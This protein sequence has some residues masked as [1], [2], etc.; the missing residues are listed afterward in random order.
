MSTK[1]RVL[2]CLAGLIAVLAGPACWAGA[3]DTVAGPAA[4]AVPWC[5]TAQLHGLI[6]GQNAGAGSI[7]TTLVLRNAGRTTCMLMGYP[8]VSLVDSRHRQLGRPARWDAGPIVRIV[9]RPGDA[10][11]TMIRS[12]NPGTGTN[13]CL[14]PSAALRIYPP[15]ERVSLLVPAHLSECL[16][17]VDVRP[18]VPGTSGELPPG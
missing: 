15:N 17:L 2:S 10:A 7:F 12:A 16:G 9:L 18:L 6:G 13:D 14:P 11:S 8:G 1:T 3:A 4:A 5:R